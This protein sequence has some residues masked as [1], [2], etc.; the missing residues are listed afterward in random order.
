MPPIPFL[1]HHRLALVLRDL[2]Y[3]RNS[4]NWHLLV[5]ATSLH[6][7]EVTMS[8][9]QWWTAMPLMFPQLS[10]HMDWTN[11]KL[12]DGEESS[13]GEPQ[14]WSTRPNIDPRVLFSPCSAEEARAT[15]KGYQKRHETIRCTS[16]VRIRSTAWSNG[17]NV[18]HVYHFITD[19]TTLYL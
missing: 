9:V 2:K 16:M 11:R 8:A 15:R 12:G 19:F 18:C 3:L 6:L 14:H 4:K 7:P 5:I 1:R 10:P 13:C 17:G